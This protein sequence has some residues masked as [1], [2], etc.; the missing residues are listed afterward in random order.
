MRRLSHRMIKMNAWEL[1]PLGKMATP[2]LWVW[3]WMSGAIP[4]CFHGFLGL[5]F[6][7]K[8]MLAARF[9]KADGTKLR[10]S[11]TIIGGAVN[12]AGA[13]RR[14]SHGLL[15]FFPLSSPFGKYIQ[16]H[17]QTRT[18]ILDDSAK[19]QIKLKCAF[20]NTHFQQY[21]HMAIGVWLRSEKDM[22]N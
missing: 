11:I 18:S 22:A 21:L 12:D 7:I 13:I 6:T 10:L 5:Y 4:A 15:S 8:W 19:P 1:F 14:V 9:A 17:R 3:F 20:F 2:V 16:P